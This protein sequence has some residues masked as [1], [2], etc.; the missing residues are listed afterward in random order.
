MQITKIEHV[1]ISPF[2]RAYNL[3]AFKLFQRPNGLLFLRWEPRYHR[4]STKR[5]YGKK[6]LSWHITGKLL[7][8]L[9]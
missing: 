3:K 7:L 1:L 4:E 5:W 2:A 6:G 9:L 8:L